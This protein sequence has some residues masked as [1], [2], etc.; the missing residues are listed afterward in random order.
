MS[1]RTRRRLRRLRPLLWIVL[2]GSGALLL[3]GAL[4][5][6]Q[7]LQARHD[8]SQA[9]AAIERA[10][11][12]AVDGDQTGARALLETAQARSHR[13]T[14]RI[15]GFVWSTYGHL[16]VAGPVVREARGL[17]EVTDL[18]TGQVLGPLVSAAPSST[19]W[20]GQADLAALRRTATP[21]ATADARLTDARRRLDRLPEGRVRQLG[22]ARADLSLSLAALAVD[23]RDAA[24]AAKVL[25]A[26]LGADH[27]THLLLVAQNQAEERATGGLIGSYALL[28]A[29]D[30]RIRLTRSGAD[31]ELQ[32]ASSPVADLGPDFTARY[33]VA[34]A[35][36][37]W[38]S[39]N[40]TPDVPSAG[41]ILAG[42]SAQQLGQHVDAVVLVD[43][44]ALSRVLSATGPV[45]VPGLGTM[46]SDNAVPLLLKEAY[47]RFA[48]PADQ[49]ARKQVLSKALDQVVLRL[50][51]PVGGQLAR[52]LAK[53][54]AS[55][56]VQVFATDATVERELLRSRIGGA[57]PGHGP[58]LSVVTQDVGGSKLDYYLHRAVEYDAMPSPIAVDL[59]AG[60]ETV[61]DGTV[62]LRLRNDAPASGLPA[63]VTTR[64]DDPR[65]R[66]V[67]QLKSWV[68]VYLGPRATYSKATLDGRD[69]ALS[70]QVE[71]G[72]SVF[73]S[74][75]TIDPGQTVTLVLAF[76]QPAGTR[77]VLL[78]RQQPRLE[79]DALVVR[80]SGGYVSLYDAD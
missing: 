42:L 48:S 17:V 54:T 80:R 19:T 20:T 18:V 57:L 62:T 75:V 27:P 15:T 35:A 22:R 7:A 13:A 59:G 45:D 1:R 41:A 77:S 44:V 43:T 4:V 49:T 64:A 68:S 58:F 36:S 8:L 39:A 47:A 23:V 21:L 55:G 14:G 3:G 16:P 5:G 56:H 72:L 65:A 51:Q 24:V 34:Q 73:S 32:D 26:L 12:A 10:R 38:R 25:P 63:Y 67:G 78:W 69:I 71:G 52:Q 61:E 40:L 76:Q 74:F 9:R 28:T 31:T 60:P 79:P 70:S 33:G 46:T 2:I 50:Q 29:T 66:P 37:T 6:L 30:G 53:A 11:Q